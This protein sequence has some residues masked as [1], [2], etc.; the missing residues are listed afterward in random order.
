ITTTGRIDPNLNPA[1]GNRGFTGHEEMDEVGLVHMNG[2]VYDP[3]LGRFVSSDSIIETPDGLQ[4]YNRY[5]YALNNP[6]KYTDPSG[7]CI[8]DYCVVEIAMLIAGYE[9]SAHGNSNW[10]IV[11]T[12]MM[13]YAGGELVE[14]GLGAQPFVNGSGPL[15]YNAFNA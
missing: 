14:A 15:A 11:G 5:S 9:L 10:R 12:V 6:L 4:G 13:M 7:H 1:N 8:Y 3:F 2:R